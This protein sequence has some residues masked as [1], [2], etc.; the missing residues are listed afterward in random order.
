MLELIKAH[1]YATVAVFVSVCLALCAIILNDCEPDPEEERERHR[2]N[3]Y[4]DSWGDE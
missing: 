3:G 1:P 2:H 4:H